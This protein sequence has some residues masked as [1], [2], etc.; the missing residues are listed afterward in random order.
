[1]G[2]RHPI[3][4]LPSVIK[5][6]EQF[7]RRLSELADGEKNLYAECMVRSAEELLND[8]LLQHPEGIDDIF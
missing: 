4:A 2:K 6:Q 5:D 8:Y 7:I 3:D 1:M